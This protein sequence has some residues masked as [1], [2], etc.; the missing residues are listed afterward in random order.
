[1]MQ[2]CYGDGLS[3]I[4]QK[5]NLLRAYCCLRYH[6]WKYNPMLYTATARFKG[7]FYLKVDF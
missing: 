7:G 5:K 2:G 6:V 1:M 3:T 4:Y